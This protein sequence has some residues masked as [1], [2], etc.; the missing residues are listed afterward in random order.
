[1][2]R[3]E[4][5]WARRLII[6]SIVDLPAPERPITPTKLPGGIENEAL[7]TAALVPNRHVKPSTTSMYCSSKPNRRL[8]GAMAS[9]RILQLC[10]SRATAKAATASRT[11]SSKRHAIVIKP[12]DDGQQRD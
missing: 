9:L 2:I 7:S 10:D 6:R 1:M 8:S 3:P 5:G 12:V 4:V 11:P